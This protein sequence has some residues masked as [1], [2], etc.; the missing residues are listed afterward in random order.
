MK[1]KMKVLVVEPA[2]K[3]YVKEIT[4]S[5]K[6]MQMLVDGP[7]QTVYPFEDLVGIVC[8]DEAKL[9]P[10]KFAPN[11]GLKDEN[12]KLYDIICGT[13]FVVGLDEEDFCSLNDDQIAKFKALYEEPEIFKKKND[14][15]I[16]EKCSGGL[17][18]FSLWMLDDTP[19]NEEYLFMSYRYWKEKGREFKKKYYR[20]VYEGV[21][22]SEKSNIET[23]E[24]LYGTFNI[25]HPKEYHERSM[26]LGDIIEISDENRN[27]KAL[28][29]D[30]ISF[31]EIPFS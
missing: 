11:R 20:K 14:E 1:E 8:N 9:F 21:C 16:S 2:K 27:K 25:N 3:P 23:A 18:T 12:G 5:L 6:A 26:S 29:C 7:I 15:I 17:K 24:S 31:V 30:T 10:T 19:E 4:H 13:F 22:V 28:F